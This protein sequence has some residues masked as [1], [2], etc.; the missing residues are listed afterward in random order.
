MCNHDDVAAEQD[1]EKV[2]RN[3]SSSK[4]RLAFFIFIPQKT[5]CLSTYH[6]L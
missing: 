6:F 5:A 2:G 4:G 3:C 1:V